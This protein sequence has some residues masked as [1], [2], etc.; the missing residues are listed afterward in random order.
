[1]KQ[2]RK[3]KSKIHLLAIVLGILFSAFIFF[4]IGIK[5]ISGFFDDGPGTIKLSLESF[6]SWDNPGPYFITY[7]IGYV[8]VFLKPLWGS[9]I[10]M[11]A[12]IYLLLFAAFHVPPIFAIIGF[13]VGALYFAYWFFE[14]RNHKYAA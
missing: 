9:I 14:K 5:V 1:M 2:K 4:T 13:V 11:A 8:L 6:L 12:N 3:P 10:I 7:T